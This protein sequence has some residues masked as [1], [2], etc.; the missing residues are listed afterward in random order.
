MSM[1]QVHQA[2]LLMELEVGKGGAPPLTGPAGL[3]EEAAA[4]W[5]A[6]VRRVHI[7]EFHADVAAQ[8]RAMGVP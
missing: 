8:L 4:L 1:L 3:L 7:S 5:G 2:W 6:T